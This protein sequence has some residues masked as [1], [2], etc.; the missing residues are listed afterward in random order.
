[1]STNPSGLAHPA[2]RRLS[3]LFRVLRRRRVRRVI[4]RWLALAVVVAV[5]AAA[6]VA[7]QAVDRLNV[8]SPGSSGGAPV[9]VPTSEPTTAPGVAVDPLDA[10]V[11]KGLYLKPVYHDMKITRDGTVVEGLDVHG[12]IIVKAN[13]VIIRNSRVRGADTGSKN[14]IIDMTRDF[15]NLLVED[16]EI[17]ATHEWFYV[18]GIIGHDFTL[19]RVNIHHVIDNVQVTGSNVT[20]EDSW[21]HDNLHYDVDPVQDG[22]PSHDDSVEIFGGNNIVIRNNH[23]SGA[24]NASLQLSQRRGPISDVTFE[25]NT[26]NNGF[27]SIIFSRIDEVPAQNVKI[28]DN[29]FGR[30]TRY[31]QCAII[32][33]LNIQ[34]VIENNFYSDGEPVTSWRRGK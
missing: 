34:P 6:S 19:R 14:G 29:I 15:K 17:F 2:P 10:G 30:G 13:D 5:A 26:V 25:N 28:K 1:M 21:F 20:I 33:P 32:G 7:L 9:A 16:T 27:C 31:E 8:G 4:G 18:N 23:M 11:P 3:D 12:R 24:W 22:T